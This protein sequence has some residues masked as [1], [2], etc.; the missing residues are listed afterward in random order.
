MLHA[1]TDTFGTWNEK[2]WL[3]ELYCPNCQQPGYTIGTGQ[4]MEHGDLSEYTKDNPKPCGKPGIILN[5][6]GGDTNGR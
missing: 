2:V 1:V 6:P 5:F 3:K 4:I